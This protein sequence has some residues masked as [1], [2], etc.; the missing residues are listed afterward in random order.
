MISTPTD[1]I[2]LT[3][4]VGNNDNSCLISGHFTGTINFMNGTTLSSRGGSDI[5]IV[6]LDTNG[7][8]TWIRQQG[9]VN[10]EFCHSITTDGLN[11]VAYTGEYR[12]STILEGRTFESE[13]NELT[14]FVIG[15]QDDCN[16]HLDIHQNPVPSRLYQTTQTISTK[17]NIPS[18]NVVSLKAGD[19]IHFQPG[20]YA[21]AESYVHATIAAAEDC[22]DSQN[23]QSEEVSYRQE[24][25]VPPSPTKASLRCYPNPFQQS[26]TIEYQ[27]P[28][29][30]VVDIAIYGMRGETIAQLSTNE[31]LTAGTYQ[32]DYPA[33]GLTT[34]IYY[35]VC[36]VGQD[37]LTEKL[38]VIGR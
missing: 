17:G 16:E 2:K 3:E 28:E 32:I 10:D 1:S 23:Y 34:G 6:R 31:I 26:T 13:S 27:V 37:L 25:A 18:N 30:A 20:F 38:V 4:I 22:D 9:Q 8:I 29:T 7:N 12:Q 21:Q 35:V 14:G 33:L 15:F 5:F 24:E 19:Q 11:I 36:R